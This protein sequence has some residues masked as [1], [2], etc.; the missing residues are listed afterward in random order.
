MAPRGALCSADPH[1]SPP[2][3]AGSG[4]WLHAAAAR[5]G[6]TDQLWRNS[7]LGVVSEQRGQVR[8]EGWPAANK[9]ALSFISA[10]LRRPASVT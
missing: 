10:G 6:Q 7:S 3:T 5:T 4:P 8:S 1:P 2:K 9:E